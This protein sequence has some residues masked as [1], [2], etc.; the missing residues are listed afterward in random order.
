[1]RKLERDGSLKIR[2]KTKLRLTF[3]IDFETQRS[4]VLR[5][6]MATVA[7]RT[8]D[9][10][11]NKTGGDAV[12]ENK[13]ANLVINNERVSPFDIRSKER[14]HAQ[15]KLVQHRSRLHQSVSQPYPSSRIL[16]SAS[17]LTSA[18]N[19]ASS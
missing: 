4:V 14:R 1:M 17:P 7:T 3:V 16:A 2:T 15:G 11:Q 10:R 6:Q 5:D 18:S 13:G 8:K 9:M 12:N 19:S